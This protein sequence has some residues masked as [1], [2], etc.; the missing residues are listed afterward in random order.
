MRIVQL[1]FVLLC[2]ALL[3]ICTGCAPSEARATA[4]Q[5]DVPAPDFALPALDGEVVR[6]SELAG[7][8]VVVNFWAS[9]CA[10][11]VNET[12]R[13]VE[14]YDTYRDRGLR[15]LGVDSLYLDSRP[16]VEA[17]ANQYSVSYPILLDDDGE[18]SKQW[19]AQQLPRSYVVD[20]AGVVRFVRIGELTER[21]FEAQIAPLLNE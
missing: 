7:E 9:W 1:R 2:C 3:I 12:P 11:C 16:D 4:P 20:R 15:I 13:L 8:V 6:L 18:T 21:D 14:W 19:R 10:P 5:L 17:F